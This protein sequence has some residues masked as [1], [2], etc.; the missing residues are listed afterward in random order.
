[1]RRPFF[2][3]CSLVLECEIFFVFFPLI[4]FFFFFSFLE[5]NLGR[6]C[7]YFLFTCRFFIIERRIVSLKRGGGIPPFVFFVAKWT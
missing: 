4:L 7:L 6:G 2:L 1:M 3:S 5:G